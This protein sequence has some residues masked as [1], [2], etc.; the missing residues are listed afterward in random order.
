MQRDSRRMEKIQEICDVYLV[1]RLSIRWD[2]AKRQIDRVGTH[3]GKPPHNPT[4]QRQHDKR[5]RNRTSHKA[6]H[7]ELPR[8]LTF[9]RACVHAHHQEDYVGGAEDVEHFEREVPYLVE[10]GAVVGGPEGEEE[11]ARAEDDE[12]EELGY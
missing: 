2:T 12:V 6:A 3:L 5:R 7:A 4:L 8:L 11:V 1:S 9:A 10:L